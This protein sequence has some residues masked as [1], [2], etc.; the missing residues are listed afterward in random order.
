MKRSSPQV[1]DQGV[2][3]GRRSGKGFSTPFCAE[4]F[5]GQR[6]ASEA[7]C[8]VANGLRLFDAPGRAGDLVCLSFRTQAVHLGL[9]KT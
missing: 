7:V 5:P 1:S 4:C 6:L 9:L 8:R 3:L 2:W